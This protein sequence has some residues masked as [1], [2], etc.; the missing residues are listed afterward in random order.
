MLGDVRAPLFLR[1]FM[2]LQVE[3]VVD[4]L[5]D[6]WITRAFVVLRCGPGAIAIILRREGVGFIRERIPVPLALE[7]PNGAIPEMMEFRLA[8]LWAPIFEVGHCVVAADGGRQRVGRVHRCGEEEPRK[9]DSHDGKE[10]LEHVSPFVDSA[11]RAKV[12]FDGA[13][14]RR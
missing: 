11:V 14:R 13:L 6:I 1:P 8:L 2:D 12:R 3:L 10:L 9:R 7:E 4:D 5:P